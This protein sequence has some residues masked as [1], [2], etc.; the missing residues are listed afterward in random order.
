MRFIAVSTP[1]RQEQERTTVTRI[2]PTVTS[3]ALPEPGRALGIADLA[4]DIY[5]M[6]RNELDGA[7]TER[8]LPLTESQ[9]PEARELLR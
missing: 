8:A 9:R 5:T 6:A 4:L 2:R 7:L 3:Q 1:S